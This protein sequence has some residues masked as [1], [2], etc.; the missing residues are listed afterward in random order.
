[1]KIEGGKKMYGAD[2][3]KSCIQEWFAEA[4][5][6]VEVAKT[7]HEIQMEAEKQLEYMMKQYIAELNNTLTD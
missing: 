5:N 6:P 2:D 3:I 1:M 4:L 7:Y